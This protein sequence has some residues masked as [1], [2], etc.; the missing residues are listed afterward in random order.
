MPMMHDRPVS[1][2]TDYHDAYDVWLERP[3]PGTV[4]FSRLAA[5]SWSVHR[6]QMFDLFDRLGLAHPA[7]QAAS[8]FSPEDRL[9]LYEEPYAHCGEGK[10]LTTAQEVLEAGEGDLMASAFIDDFPGLSYRYFVIA[11]HGA[12]FE[13]WS[14]ED[15]RSNCGDG[16][17]SPISQVRGPVHGL[18]DIQQACL[19]VRNPIFAIDFVAQRTPGGIRLLAIDWN[20]APRLSGTPAHTEFIKLYRSNEGIA[21]ALRDSVLAEANRLGV[22]ILDNNRILLSAPTHL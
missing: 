11:G 10:R 16:D 14:T 2:R 20:P 9:V 6:T 15:W 12:W 5:D 21:G 1:L 8:Q 7:Y 4:C 22:E 13:H 19:P 3:G 17:L 18:P